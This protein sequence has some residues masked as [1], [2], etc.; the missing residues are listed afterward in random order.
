MHFLQEV[1][2]GADSAAVSVGGQVSQLAMLQAGAGLVGTASD[3][4]PASVA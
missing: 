3:G 2:R 4:S 1:L